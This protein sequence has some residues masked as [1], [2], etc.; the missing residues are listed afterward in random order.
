MP[1]P[2]V[3]ST[4]PRRPARALLVALALAATSAVSA[5]ATGFDAQ[6]TDLYNAPAGS[7]V[8]TGDVKGLNMLVVAD[9]EGS[10][11]LVAALANTTDEDDQLLAIT[12]GDVDEPVTVSGLDT[13][14]PVG[15]GELVQLAA[16]EPEGA[17][18][19]IGLSGDSVQVGR[20]VPVSMRFERAGAVMADLLVVEREDEF[21]DVPSLPTSAPTGPAEEPTVPPTPGPGG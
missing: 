20:L 5:C 19:A 12:A 18:G 1:R 4:S 7:D 13:P 10:G 11:T 14:V 6:T 9:G 8:R 17:G 16:L 3:T 15:A 21:E 2:A